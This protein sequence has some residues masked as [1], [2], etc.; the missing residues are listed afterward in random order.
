MQMKPDRCSIVLL[1]MVPSTAMMMLSNI[2]VDN[3]KRCSSQ[4][5][6]FVAQRPDK[7]RSAWFPVEQAIPAVAVHKRPR[8]TTHRESHYPGQHLWCAD[9][10]T[11]TLCD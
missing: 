4:V 11:A 6:S 9:A 5:V 1:W 8:S 2:G 7:L 10:H 3:N